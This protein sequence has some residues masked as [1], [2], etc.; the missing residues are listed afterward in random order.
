M[1]LSTSHP[2]SAWRQAMRDYVLNTNESETDS[3][4]LRR[5]GLKPSVL[6]LCGD[7]SGKQVLDIGSADGWL[8]RE[9]RA[10]TLVECDI[11]PPDSP[12]RPF[13]LC[14]AA[15][16][17]FARDSFDVVVSSFVIHH[18]PE[19]V[20]RPALREMG[21]VLRPGGSLLVAE[22]PVGNDMGH[23]A[24]P[25]GEALAEAGFAE[26]RSGDVG[27]WIRCARGRKG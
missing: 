25:L 11:V 13:V 2:G 15:A 8:R 3:A 9:L 4:Y 5:V 16:L 21:R 23:P 14:D 19:D 27:R 24:P 26:I 7:C 1:A 10:R 18:L 20:Q 17:P 6:D 12:S 22:V